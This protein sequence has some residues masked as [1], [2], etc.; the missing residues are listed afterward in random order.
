MTEDTVSFDAIE[1][2]WNPGVT[3]RTAGECIGAL[4]EGLAREG[5]F[6]DAE[7][8]TR[9]A[10]AMWSTL[11]N[12]GVPPTVVDLPRLGDALGRHWLLVART[13]LDGVNVIKIAG[14]A[15]DALSV[16]LTCRLMWLQWCE[17]LRL[18][19]GAIA[20]HGEAIDRAS[21]ALASTPSEATAWPARRLEA[22]ATDWDVLRRV[23]DPDEVVRLLVARSVSLGPGAP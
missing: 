17:R 15:V 9:I 6:L 14:A 18:S 8:V 1:K 20:A 2:A 7:S 3:G 10:L 22:L 23:V 5:V 12:R 11:D 13:F 21:V 16:A 4:C 19:E